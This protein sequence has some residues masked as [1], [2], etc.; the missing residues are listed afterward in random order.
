[1]KD[2]MPT[3]SVPYRL[4]VN[5]RERVATY[6]KNQKVNVLKFQHLTPYLFCPKFA[7]YTVVS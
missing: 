1:M 7:L 6:N 5:E 3:C 4:K 2:D